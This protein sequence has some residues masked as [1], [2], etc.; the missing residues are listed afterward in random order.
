LIRITINNWRNIVAFDQT[1][2]NALYLTGPNGS[3][4]SSVLEAV[5]FAYFGRC[6]RT[7]RRGGGYAECVREGTPEATI[8]IEDGDLTIHCTITVN[9]KQTFSATWTDGRVAETRKELWQELGIDP[10]HAELV[11]SMGDAITSGDF[12]AVISEYLCEG[13]EPDAV[14]LKCGSHFP[15]IETFIA[16]A[17]PTSIDGWR[18]VGDLAYTTRTSRNR[19]IKELTG[20]VAQLGFT[21]A[22]EE[23]VETLRSWLR[24]GG[25]KRDLLQGEAGAARSAVHLA[26]DVR[27]ELERVVKAGVSKTGTATAAH[28]KASSA[29]SNL[30]RDKDLVE[31]EITGLCGAEGPCPT[32]GQDMPPDRQ[33]ARV[34]ARTA[35]ESRAEGVYAAIDIAEKVEK[36]ARA[37]AEREQKANLESVR[38]V[39][40]A[41]ARLAADTPC[42]EPDA[43]QADIE[44]VDA[45][46]GIIEAKIRAAADAA[47]ATGM[48][49]RLYELED[50]IGHLSWAVKAFRD[51]EL[52]NQFTAGQKKTEFV[53]AVNAELKPFGYTLAIEACG[54]TMQAQLI[55]PNG[56]RRA[57]ADQSTGRR[58]LAM[59]AI[60]LAFANAASPILMDNM[61]CLEGGNKNTVRVRMHSA[62]VPIVLAGVW[63]VP[64]FAGTNREEKRIEAI[65]L[66]EDAFAPCVVRWMEETK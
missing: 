29:Y 62:P 15:W 6:S 37:A 54:K 18:A 25:T 66:I 16:G 35:A 44:A 41:K 48:K 28:A 42:R 50:E 49:K 40:D 23:S 30:S 33:A 1:F 47:A 11:A 31:R 13:I 59:F 38:A 22:P 34:E 21:V 4:K 64:P 8:R 12:D 39:A 27:A 61:D 36:K 60:S 3:G 10:R 19:E 63:T 24:Q 43:I 51:G 32:C 65:K 14:Y 52:I 9:K 26:P 2:A 56:V 5:R 17:A 7:D 46:L 45:E 53:A 20:A 57:L 58:W 55:L